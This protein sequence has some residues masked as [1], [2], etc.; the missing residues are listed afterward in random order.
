LP[1]YSLASFAAPATLPLG[2]LEANS[3][4]WV[5]GAVTFAPIW[6]KAQSTNKVAWCAPGTAQNTTSRRV[7]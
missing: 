3:S 2:T 5:A 1:N 4:P 7:G 6:L